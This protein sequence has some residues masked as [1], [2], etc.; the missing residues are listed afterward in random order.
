MHCDYKR[1]KVSDAEY[2]IAEPLEAIAR[3]LRPIEAVYMPGPDGFPKQPD[4]FLDVEVH[5]LSQEPSLT[6]LSVG[7]ERGYWRAE[8]FADHVMEWLPEFALNYAELK[9][10][11]PGNMAQLLRQ[12]AKTVYQSEKFKN[13]GEFGELFLHIAIRQVFGSLP[14][15]S[16]IFYKSSPNDP[17]KGFDAVHVVGPPDNMELWLG[18][19]KF[20]HDFARAVHDVAAELEK[21]METDFLRNEFVLIRGKIDPSWPHAQRLKELLSRN[22]PLDQIF[23]RAC[24]A[25]LLTYDSACLKAHTICDRAYKRAFEDEMRKNHLHFK[26][27]S[28][29]GSITIHLILLPLNTKREL[30]K[31]LD[32]KLGNWRNI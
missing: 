17:V 20:Y 29:P 22:K 11:Q 5:D 4:P 32:G 7:Y 9:S 18:E 21:H 2:A 14:A 13:R 24:I 6:G 19:A 23:T 31:L 25:V 15:I 12:A 3:W 16:K 28:L 8:Q 30:I 10:V 27:Q 1:R 26:K